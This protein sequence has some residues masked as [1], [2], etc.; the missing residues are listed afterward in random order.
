MEISVL[1]DENRRFYDVRISKILN[2]N[3]ESADRLMSFRDVTERKNIEFEK[4]VLLNT[5][6][7][8]NKELQ[9]ALQEMKT[10]R[11][12]IPI[13]T[14][15]KKSVMTRDIGIELN[16]LLKSTRKRNSVM[17]SAPSVRI[18]YMENTDGIRRGRKKLK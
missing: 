15:C 14:H 17:V 1:S 18:K 13:C 2:I 4:D 6:D 12:L 9:Q 16:H 10:P 3:N 5:L 7:K 11:G 8:K